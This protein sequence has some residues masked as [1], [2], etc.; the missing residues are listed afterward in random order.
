MELLPEF[1][2]WRTPGVRAGDIQVDHEPESD[3]V[4]AMGEVSDIEDGSWA[5][6]TVEDDIAGQLF[7]LDSLR[8]DPVP[9]K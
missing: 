2:G 9:Y 4:G 7:E 1:S 6:A 5:N 3:E 8:P